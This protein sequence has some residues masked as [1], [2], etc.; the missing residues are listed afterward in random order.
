MAKE[1]TEEFAKAPYATL[2]VSP[3]SML[4]DVMSAAVEACKKESGHGSM[5]RDRRRWQT[6]GN[7]KSDE[8]NEQ[9]SDGSAEARRCLSR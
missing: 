1:P 6:E 3:V 8:R 5:L 9:L 7:G 4:P 2:H